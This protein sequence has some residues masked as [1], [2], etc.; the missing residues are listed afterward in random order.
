M[1]VNRHEPCAREAIVR[2]Y[3]HIPAGQ[4]NNL[5]SMECIPPWQRV[6]IVIEDDITDDAE[7]RALDVAPIATQPGFPY[8]TSPSATST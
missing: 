1:E 5:L 4:V 3:E 6:T 8:G 2:R 7:D